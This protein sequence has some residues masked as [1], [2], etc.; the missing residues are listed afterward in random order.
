MNAA[1]EAM[2]GVIDAQIKR[3]LARAFTQDRAMRPVRTPL[4]SGGLAISEFAP[5]DQQ[6]I[7]F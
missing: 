2:A 1:A 6:R 3:E 5:E 4:P 7:Y